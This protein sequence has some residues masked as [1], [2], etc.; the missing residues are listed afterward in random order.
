[1]TRPS[2]PR[3]VRSDAPPYRPRGARVLLPALS[4]AAGLGAGCGALDPKPASS[5]GPEPAV[6]LTE[7]AEQRLLARAEGLAS[8][9]DLDAARAEFE[10]LIATNPTLTVAYLGAGDIY[11][12]QGD[13][14]TAEQRYAKAAEIE[15][16]NFDAQYLHGLVLQIEKKIGEAVRAYLRALTI[17]PDDFNANLNLGTAYLQLGEGQQALPYAQRAVRLDPDSAAARTNLGAIYASLDRH[18]EAVTEYQQAAELTKLSAPLLLNL[19]D[20]LGKIGKYE[21]MANT[22]TQLIELKATAEA[23]ERLGSAQF[24]MRR[25]PE[26]EASFR[27]AIDLDGQYYPAINGAAV[28]ALNRYVW[29]NQLDENAKNEAIS[30]F[31]RSLLI[32]KKQP[33]VIDLLSRYK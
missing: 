15:P 8:K 23:F 27:K 4:L 17:K 10:R 30:L 12:Q 1:M 9:G 29:S 7:S 33:Q 26:A 3:D 14:R 19:A 13:Y 16:G 5:R 25:Y 28:C 11:R 20:S 32:E 2:S 21:E 24:R 18:A 31:R 6:G 22:L